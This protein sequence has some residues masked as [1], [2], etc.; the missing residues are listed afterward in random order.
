MPISQALIAAEVDPARRGVAMGVTQN[1]GA[2][3]L[4]NFLAP[5]VLVAIATAFG[6]RRAFYLAAVP[7][8]LM[9]FLIF[10]YVREPLAT[11]ASAAVRQ[12]K[13]LLEGFSDRNVLI[14]TVISVLLVGYLVI[15]YTFMPLIL[16]QQH[17]LDRQTMSWLMAT[18]GLVSMGYAI[19]IPGASD[20]V[21]RRPV[22]IAVAIMGAITPLGVLLFHGSGWELFALFAA[23]AVISG[24]FPISM[25]TIPTES[26]DARLLATAMGL[27]MGIGEILGGG[28]R[29]GGRR[30]GRGPLRIAVDPVDTHR[31]HPGHRPDFY[32]A[33][34]DCAGGATTPDRGAIGTGYRA[35]RGKRLASIAGGS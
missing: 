18:F 16:I 21:G 6:W 35:D 22:M 12:G 20:L 27:T 1:F 3:L 23:G 10:Q 4:G 9:A 31:A 34:R 7:G 24:I 14:C 25:A 13:S 15:F 17:G 33:S 30:P 11:S 5:V 2:N 19:L 26:V 29:A 32:I 8:L 28:L